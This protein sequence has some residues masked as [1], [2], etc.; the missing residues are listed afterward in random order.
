MDIKVKM[1]LLDINMQ[2]LRA[3]A[4]DAIAAVEFKGAEEQMEALHS[5]E[6]W[7]DLLLQ[8]IGFP[9]EIT[10]GY[11]AWSEERAR[12]VRAMIDKWAEGA[13]QKRMEDW[14]VP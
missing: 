12:K 1:E 7:H 11:E 2:Q 13:R 6:M 10:E 9:R 5:M 3:T 4:L 14:N 8:A